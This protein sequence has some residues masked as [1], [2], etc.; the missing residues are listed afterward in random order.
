[1]KY[2]KEK[3]VACRARRLYKLGNNKAQAEAAAS[4]GQGSQC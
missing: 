4:T 3:Q 2:K 1:M